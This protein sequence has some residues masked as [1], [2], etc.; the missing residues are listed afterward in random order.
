VRRNQAFTLIE[1][2]PAT[3]SMSV[4]EM[5]RQLILDK[6]HCCLSMPCFRRTSCN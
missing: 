4:I 2:W 1:N 6:F 3:G 5:L